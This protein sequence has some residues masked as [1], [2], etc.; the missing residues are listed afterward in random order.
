MSFEPFESL[1]IRRTGI[2]VTR[3]GF[4][5]ASI[6]GLYSDVSDDVAVETVRHAIELGVRYLDVA[7]L[8]GRGLAEM[9]IGAALRGVPRDRFVVSTKVGRLIPTQAADGDRDGM[10]FDFSRRGVHASLESSLDRLGLERVDIV[11]LHDPDD[12]WQEAIDEAYPALH[13]LRA[14]GVVGAIGVGM[15][16]AAMLTRF[17]RETDIDVVLL[18]GRYTLLDQSALDGLLPLCVEHKIGVVIGGVMNSG[19]LADPR[20]GSRFDYEA[21]APGIL[22]RA[23]RLAA[24]CKAHGVPLRAAAVQFAAAHPAVV[25][26]LAGV[27]S[28]EHLD[29]YPALMRWPIPTGL[30]TDLGDSGLL[31]ENA[32]VPS[33]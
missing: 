20:P 3:L 11:F 15:N 4:G 19:I 12:H 21:A 10:V 32:P 17:A 33:G 18:A 23:Q 5:A 6:G 2:S 26:V 30:W 22:E 7:P 31:P 8:Y 9:R 25:S 29:E 13:E 27:R 24:L 28:A 16:Q 14:A 1:S